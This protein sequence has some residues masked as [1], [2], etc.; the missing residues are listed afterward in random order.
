V[1]AH[2][3]SIK[4][5][6]IHASSILLVCCSVALFLVPNYAYEITKPEIT[7]AERSAAYSK[8]ISKL[9]DPSSDLDRP[10]LIETFKDWEKLENGHEDTLEATKD[11]HLWYAKIFVSLLVIHLIVLYGY[12]LRKPH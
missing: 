3:V 1:G 4:I 8:L 7:R 6:L 12:V 9:G 5:F 10:K 11:F 2:N